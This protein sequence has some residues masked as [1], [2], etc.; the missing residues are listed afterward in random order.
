MNPGSLGG[1]W[2]SVSLAALCSVSVFSATVETAA[3][4]DFCWCCCKLF[5]LLRSFSPSPLSL[6]FPL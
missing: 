5:F 3:G 2:A 6:K 1:A 4:L